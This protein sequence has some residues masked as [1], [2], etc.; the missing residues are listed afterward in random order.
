MSRSVD[1]GIL[2]I[3]KRRSGLI[4]ASAAQQAGIDQRCLIRRTESALLERVVPG[5]YRFN[6]SECPPELRA[7][8]AAMRVER[9]WVSHTSAAAIWN[10]TLP[11]GR[12]RPEISVVRPA[13]PRLIGVRSHR[14][15]TYPDTAD[16]ST[17]GGIR[18]SR[19]AACLIELA[20]EFEFPELELALDSLLHNRALKLGQLS[21]A[22]ARHGSF[23]GVRSLRTMLEERQNGGGILRSWLEQKSF[24][25]IRKAGLPTPVRNFK[26]VFPNGRVRII[27]LAWPD[28]LVGLEVESW[29]YH[30]RSTDWGK[31]VIRNRK[32]AVSDW[33]I[34]PCVVADT[35]D[36]SSLLDDLRAVL[37]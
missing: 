21:S 33:T 34:L 4:P 22:I 8:A 12:A 28:R 37:L 14:V 2:E 32:D 10:A 18:T 1:Q 6:Q 27:D 11:I 36:P 13:S 30:E 5:I 25:T 3:A 31:T 29:E 16:L 23:A 20:S 9:S 15:S 35:R 17:V 26:V 19:P 24:S 7:R